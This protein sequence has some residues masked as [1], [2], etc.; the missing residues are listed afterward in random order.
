M[1]EEEQKTQKVVV[2]LPRNKDVVFSPCLATCHATVLGHYLLFSL[3]LVLVLPPFL[4]LS[5]SVIRSDLQRKDFLYL[6]II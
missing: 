6:A 2:H 1:V 3:V 4:Y 5:L